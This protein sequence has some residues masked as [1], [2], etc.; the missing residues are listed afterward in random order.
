MYSDESVLFL[1]IF[2]CFY[3]QYSQIQTI[4]GKYVFSFLV[5]V[6]LGADS[7]IFG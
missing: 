7:Q 2:D 3:D 6:I 4:L 5:F 1:S